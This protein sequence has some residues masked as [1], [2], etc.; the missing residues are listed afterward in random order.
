MNYFSLF[1]SNILVNNLVLINF[2]GLCPFMG[3]SKKFSTA[4]GLGSATV[5]VITI[6]SILSWLVNYYILIPLN[7][8]CLRIMTYMLIISVSVQII[9]IVIR[10]F[11]PI[12]Y[13]LLGIY[14][15]LITSNCSVLAIPLLCLNLNFN[16]LESVVYGFSSSIGFFLVLVVFSSIRERLLL[17]DIP[18]PFKG[19]PIALITASFMSVAFMGFNGLVRV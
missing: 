4:I 1:L 17:S 9:E 7:L 8:I 18:F 2:L 10:T 19:N 6:I 15:P 16:F 3:T 12:L 11:S 13:R 14:L 5:F